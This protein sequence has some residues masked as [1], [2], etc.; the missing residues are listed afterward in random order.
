MPVTLQQVRAQLDRDEP[1]YG[2]AAQ[3]GAD[4]VP[5]LMLLVGEGDPGLASKATYLAAFIGADESAAVV[6]RAS[7]SP[8]P[9]VRVAAAGSL[10][11]LKGI[12][13]PLVTSLLEDQDA[14]VRHLALK[15]L[16]VH[17]PIGVKTKVQQISLGDPDVTVR[18]LASQVVNLLP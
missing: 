13:A 15:A 2:Q 6:E 8:D 7:R 5:Q 17:H 14:G 4:A 11:Y 18:Q 12:S 1:D 16:E 9:V 3:L 10:S